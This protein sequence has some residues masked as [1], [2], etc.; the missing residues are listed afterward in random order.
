MANGGDRRGRAFL[1]R[2]TEREKGKRRRT[3]RSRR[4]PVLIRTF[5]AAAWPKSSTSVTG[6][7][8]TAQFGLS[9]AE[10][11][12][13]GR[14]P[15]DSVF[16]AQARPKSLLRPCPGRKPPFRPTPGRRA[17]SFAFFSFYTIVSEIATKNM[18]VLKKIL[19]MKLKYV[20]RE[21]V[22]MNSG[23][24]IVSETASL[25]FQ[26]SRCRKWYSYIQPSEMYM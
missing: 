1:Q 13:F 21:C 8:K 19:K 23:M 15:A 17:T 16:S 26:Y 24:P 12:I 7:P 3:E 4:R 6:G 9:A 14:A 18:I 2:R 22:G 10:A 25:C 20:Q 5:S 11:T